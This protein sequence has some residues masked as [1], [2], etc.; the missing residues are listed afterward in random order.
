MTVNRR[1]L[2]VA[3]HFPPV[4]VSSGIQRTLKFCTYLRD[5]GWDPLVLTVSPGAYEVTSPDQLKEIPDDV[6]V[7]RAFGL[8]TSRH[9]SFRGRYL[10]YLAQPD[11]WISWWPAAVLAGMRMIKKYQ[12]DA[13][14]S[15]VPR[16]TAQLSG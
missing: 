12:P 11:R 13:V 10:N 14:V 1:L 6:I 3:Y 2:M 5:H 8:D 4:K 9:L 16:A 7:E 15:T